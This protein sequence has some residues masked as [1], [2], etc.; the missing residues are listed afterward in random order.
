[1][2]TSLRTLLPTSQD[3][4]TLYVLEKTLATFGTFLVIYVITEHW[5]MPF[6]PTADTP[7][8]EPSSNSPYR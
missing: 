5:I 3:D 8:C 4:S 7:S 2:P 1:M 6:T